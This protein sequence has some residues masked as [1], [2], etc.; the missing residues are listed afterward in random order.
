MSQSATV[1]IRPQHKLLT[2]FNVVAALIL[3]VG[4]PVMVIR[5]TMGLGACTNLSDNTA[6]G[7]WIGFD[8]LVGV[9]L[10]AGGYVTSCAVYVFG[11][12]AYHPIVRPDQNNI[13]NIITL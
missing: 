8:V 5:F 1:A 12:K 11:M 2:P 9:A 6:W 10:A 4:I 7:L 3:A 13:L